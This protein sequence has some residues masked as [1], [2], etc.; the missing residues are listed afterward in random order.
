MLSSPA[1]FPIPWGNSAGAPYI[2]AIP[3]NSQIGIQNGAASLTDGFVPDNFLPTAGGGVPP[4]GQDMN[5]ILNQVTQTQQWQQAGGGWQYDSSF[6]TSIGGYP[7]GAVLFSETVLGRQW[8]STA[9]GNTTDPDSISAAN[10][11]TPPGQIPVGAPLP[12]FSSTVPFGYVPANGLTI[13]NASSNATERANSDTLLLYRFVWL[14]FSNSECPLLTSA[15]A[16]VSR[17]ANPDAD[18]NANNQLTL[19]S[20]KGT[21][22]IGVDGMG[23]AAST[24]LANVPIVIGNTT[25][26]GSILGENLHTLTQS[27]LA[28]HTHANTLTDPTHTHGTTEINGATTMSVIGGSENFAAGNFSHQSLTACFSI[29]NAA[30]GISINNASQGGG[31]AHNNVERSMTVYWNLA[32]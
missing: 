23:G 30:T 14:N 10:W 24:F 22:L 16:P 13:G 15:G 1:K 5:G 8:L 9:D 32:L 31:G 12:S 29:N 20:L 19:P 4:F 21:A 18:Y 7:S 26:P 2:R 27:E 11:A 3:V 25:S 6:V 17:G 28:V